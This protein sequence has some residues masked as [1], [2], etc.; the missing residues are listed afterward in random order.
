MFCL[1]IWC[2]LWVRITLLLIITLIIGE[3]KLANIHE[4]FLTHYIYFYCTTWISKNASC[5]WRCISERT[6]YILNI[7]HSERHWIILISEMHLRNILNNTLFIYQFSR[8][9]GDASPELWVKIWN[10]LSPLHVRYFWRCI[11]KNIW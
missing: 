9:F 2:I 5:F 1:N 4:H 8:N 3:Y 7:G 11:S 10:Y 6:S